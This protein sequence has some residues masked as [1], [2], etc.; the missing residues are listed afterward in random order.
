MRFIPAAGG[1]APGTQ[2]V[3]LAGRRSLRQACHVPGIP[4]AGGRKLS[5]KADKPAFVLHNPANF[6]KFAYKI[7]SRG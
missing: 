4:L 3:V 2:A 6:T 7:L 5:Q 1:C